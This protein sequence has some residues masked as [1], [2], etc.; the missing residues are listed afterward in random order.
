MVPDQ[1]DDTLSGLPDWAWRLFF[2]IISVQSLICLAFLVTIPADTKNALLFGFSFPRLLMAGFFLAMNLVCGRLAYQPENNYRTWSRLFRLNTVHRVVNN[3]IWVVLVFT[4]LMV[5]LPSDLF[6]RLEAYQIRMMPIAI[7]LALFSLQAV[8]INHINRRGLNFQKWRSWISTERSLWL[9][10]GVI[11]LVTMAVY[12]VIA[13]TGIGFQVDK[14]WDKTGVPILTWQMMVAL[15]LGLVGWKFACQDGWTAR[16]RWRG[17]IVFCLIWLISAGVWISTP[18]THNHFAPGPFPPNGQ[19]FPYSDAMVYDTGA[20]FALIGAGLGGPNGYV[21]KPLL[22]AGL[23]WLHIIFGQDF[24]LLIVAQVFILAVLPALIYA[25]GKRLHSPALGMMVAILAIVKTINAINGGLLIWTVSHPKLMLSEFPLAVLLALFILISIQWI[26]KPGH[27]LYAMAAGGVFG[28]ATL[29]RHN[30]W[31]LLPLAPLVLLFVSWKQKRRAMIGVC[32][33]VGMM[34][35]TVAP[36][37][38]RFNQVEGTPFY[39]L[40]SLRKN[41]IQKR[42]ELEF[43]PT[44]TPNVNQTGEEVGQG[45]GIVDEQPLVSSDSGY[46]RLAFW[47]G[48]HFVHNL[49]TT[50]LTLPSTFQFADL[51]GTIQPQGQKSWWDA[52]W[53]GSMS[54]GKTIG[55]F[56]NLVI[57]AFGIA[58]S[59]QRGKWAGVM[60]LF[61]YLGYNLATA[62]ARTSGG[63]YVVPTDWIVFFYYALGLFQIVTMFIYL[64]SDKQPQSSDVTE[65]SDGKPIQKRFMVIV[66]G[67]FLFVGLAI[68]WTALF[69]SNQ[70]PQYGDKQLIEKLEERNFFAAA[71]LTKDEVMIFLKQKYGFGMIGRALYPRFL[72]VQKDAYAREMF[73]SLPDSP[74]NLVF[75]MIFINGKYDVYLPLEQ[76]PLE[77]PQAAEVILLGCGNKGGYIEAQVVGIQRESGDLVIL[78]NQSPFSCPSE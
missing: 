41:I 40:S 32:F 7:W 26:H 24:N 63:R 23:L 56:V 72:D 10:M 33:F 31:L 6:G 44:K 28:L 64:F 55:L 17:I 49:V 61:V 16:I 57:L 52:Q 30:V 14:F 38:Y 62:A 25:I 39:F 77:F 13:W 78:K 15:F 34:L 76:P 3:L 47:I 67:V 74:P 73:S 12:G 37:M 53:D 19:F 1:K 46:L 4:G 65:V 9:P 42:Y 58:W 43:Q 48:D 27:N 18:Q 22:V 69:F 8:L 66:A 36:W 35:V 51:T 5:L 29:V 75:R 70:Y 54:A 71:G 2:S 50:V 60:P 11:L 20:Q 21:D 59:W 68:P 45:S